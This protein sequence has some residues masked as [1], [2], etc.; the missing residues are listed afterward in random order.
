MRMML[1]AIPVGDG[2]CLTCLISSKSMISLLMTVPPILQSIVYLKQFFLILQ[3]SSHAFRIEMAAGILLQPLC[4][5]V[6]TP[7]LLVG[8]AGGKRIKHICDGNNASKQGNLYSCQSLRIAAAIEFF[9]VCQ[10]DHGG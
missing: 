7:S 3:K 8:P 5:P 1:S 6:H 4:R 9:V 2:N 10:G